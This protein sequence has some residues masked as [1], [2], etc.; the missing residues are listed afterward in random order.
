MTKTNIKTCGDYTSFIEQSKNTLY[1][2]NLKPYIKASNRLI[3][4]GSKTNFAC[5]LKNIDDCVVLTTNNTE[6]RRIKQLESYGFEIVSIGYASHDTMLLI[7]K[8]A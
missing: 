4:G 5:L 2:N 7:K 6:K 8:V 3:S 1:I